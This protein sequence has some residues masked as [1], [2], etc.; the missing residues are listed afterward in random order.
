MTAELWQADP[1]AR[2]WS[3]AGLLVVQSRGGDVRSR[4]TG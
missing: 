3:Y 4:G 2:P 1:R